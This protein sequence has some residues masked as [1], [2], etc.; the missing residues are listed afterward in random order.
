MDF[1]RDLLQKLFG[2]T[3]VKLPDSA[4]P[5]FI[6]AI[7]FLI[8]IAVGFNIFTLIFVIAGIIIYGAL[9]LRSK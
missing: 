3:D 4:T 1:L 6:F 5:L 7:I 2:T 8:L 9:K